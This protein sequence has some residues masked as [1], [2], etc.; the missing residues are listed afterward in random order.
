MLPA[1]VTPQEVKRRRDA[2][3]P[4]YLIDCREPHEYALARIE[5][6]ELIPMRSIPGEVAALQARAE[7]GPLVV[8]CHHGVRSMNVVQWLREQGIEDCQSM[9]GGIDA[10][11]LAIDSSVPRYS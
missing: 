3:E 5:G 11:S 2:A 1:E 8:Y 10:W 9:T 4:L 7:K 6:A